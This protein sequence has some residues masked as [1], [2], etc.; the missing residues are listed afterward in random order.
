MIIYSGQIV[1]NNIFKKQG[2]AFFIT[3]SMMKIGDGS[4]RNDDS[5]SH[6]RYLNRL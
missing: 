2:D 6:L 4:V 1:S 5:H 3:E